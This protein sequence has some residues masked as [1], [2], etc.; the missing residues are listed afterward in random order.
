MAKG[1]LEQILN[2]PDDPY[3]VRS[4]KIIDWGEDGEWLLACVKCDWLGREEEFVLDSSYP[5]GKACPKCGGEAD[6][7]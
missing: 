7:A 5:L 6:Y 1:L 4:P 3:T 2:P